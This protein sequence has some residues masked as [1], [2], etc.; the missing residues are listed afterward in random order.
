MKSPG[1]IFLSPES[2]HGSTPAR[3]RVKIC[4]VTHPEDAAAAVA[5]G[6]DALGMNFYPG[7]P[8]CLDPKHDGP[9]V[10]ELAGAVS[11]V[12][13]LVNPVRA[14]IDRLLAENLVDAVQLHGD[15]DPEFCR[16]L[17]DAGI[18]FAKALRVRGAESLRFA[19]EFHTRWL[20]LDAYDP[21]AY[22]GTGRTADWTLAA[23][24]VSVN[25]AG[26]CHVILSGGLGPGNVAE[27]IRRVRPFAVDVA[28][29][30]ERPD[31]RRRKD[32][33]RMKTFLSEV[34]ATNTR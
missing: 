11:R 34:Q 32:H 15:E 19:G 3:V 23:R 29:G 4:G 16:S 18:S 6:A 7:S 28:S 27:A 2:D 14:E 8:R 33:G 12:A 21:K 1:G 17:A 24:C 30:V 22:G 13:V 25:E 5:L 10:R 31:D 20:V 9:W 26:G